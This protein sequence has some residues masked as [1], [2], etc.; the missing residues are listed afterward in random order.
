MLWK[1][2]MKQG[3][4]ILSRPPSRAR[5]ETSFWK[6]WL[7]CWNLD[8]LLPEKTNTQDVRRISHTAN[9][10]RRHGYVLNR[11]QQFALID[12]GEFVR[13]HAFLA[14]PKEIALYHKPD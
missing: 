9:D 2:L 4:P 7:L 5:E 3:K 8:I 1:T 14:L 12:K 6:N 10:L 11:W 13:V